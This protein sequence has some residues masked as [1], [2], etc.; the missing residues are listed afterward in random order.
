MTRIGGAYYAGFC[1]DGPH[2]LIGDKLDFKNSQ[3]SHLRMLTTR[4]E[5]P[6][7]N[8]AC[9]QRASTMLG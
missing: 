1:S 3:G 4:H 7:L 9:W 6:K 5:S 8:P 2:M